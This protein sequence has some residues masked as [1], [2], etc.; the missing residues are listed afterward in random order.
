MRFIANTVGIIC[1]CE[2]NQVEE[3]LEKIGKKNNEFW[4]KYEEKYGPGN[5]PYGA[6]HFRVIPTLEEYLD[7]YEDFGLFDKE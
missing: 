2:D 5:K 1:T 3:A 7:Q 6:L 4:D